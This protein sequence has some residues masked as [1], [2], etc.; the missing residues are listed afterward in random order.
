MLSKESLFISG[1][2]FR[3]ILRMRNKSNQQ[4][5]EYFTT[6]LDLG[7]TDKNYRIY[8]NSDGIVFAYFGV[9]LSWEMVK[10][11]SKKEELLYMINQDGVYPL[12]FYRD[13]VYRILSTIPPTLELDGIRMHTHKVSRDIKSKV[14][15]LKIKPGSLVLD[16]CAGF[17][18]T[19]IEASN[20][21][22]RVIAV[23]KDPFVIELAK[24]NPYSKNLFTSRYITLIIGDIYELDFKDEMFDFIIHDPPRLSKSSGLLYSDDIYYKFYRILKPGGALYHYV[25]NP[26]KKY[27]RKDILHRVSHRLSIIGF[28]TKIV[29]EIEG[30]IARKNMFWI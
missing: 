12:I 26:G 10:K 3:A 22:A 1:K 8:L 18:Y 6:N 7:R 29:K 21:G 13:K 19:A 11:F 16:T 25:G 23:E 5:T 9:F 14:E 24:I 28:S 17:G 20:Y 2:Q 27:R 30:I 15:Y 4:D